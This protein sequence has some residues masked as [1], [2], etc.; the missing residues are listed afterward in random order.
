MSRQNMEI[1]RR[2]WNF[3]HVRTVRN[4]SVVHGRSGH[5]RCFLQGA[6]CLYPPDAGGASAA[7]A[8]TSEALQD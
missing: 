8:V 4:D 6:G 2:G 7:E 1:A 5:R 3:W